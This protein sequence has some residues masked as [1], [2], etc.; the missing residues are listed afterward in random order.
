LAQLLARSYTRGYYDYRLAS[1]YPGAIGN[2]IPSEADRLWVPAAELK[3]L[4]AGA[5][6]LLETRPDLGSP[7]FRMLSALW[8]RADVHAHA[9]GWRAACLG[10]RPDPPGTAGAFLTY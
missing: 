8:T 4:I 10:N 1:K 2:D 5:K 7:G 9:D 6:A 3:A